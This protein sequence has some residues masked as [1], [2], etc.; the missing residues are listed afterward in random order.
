MSDN[1]R[2]NIV[3]E[4]GKIIGEDTRTNI[5]LH[6]LLHR[7]IHVWLY[8]PSGNLIL[9]HRGKDKDTYPDLLDASV[10]GHVELGMNFEDT[11]LQEL[12]EE[13]GIKADIKDF[14]LLETIH[15]NIYDEQT[16]MTNNALRAVYAYK[17]LGKI[18]DLKIEEGKALGFEIWPLKTIFSLT[19][20]EKK[21][22]IP[23][24]YSEANLDVFRKI[25]TL[26]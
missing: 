26:P 24:I 25:Q 16:G 23:G 4:E 3:N 20:E 10:S 8:T 21:R 1:T 14:T 11:A 19:K 13:T 6:G 22:F 15:S 12:E 18:M 9:Q 5:H 2:L 7:E 17:F